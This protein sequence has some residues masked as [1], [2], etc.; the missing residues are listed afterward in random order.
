MTPTVAGSRRLR[1]TRPGERSKTPGREAVGRIGS[2]GRKPGISAV[3]CCAGWAVPA[4]LCRVARSDGRTQVRQSASQTRPSILLARAGGGPPRLFARPDNTG[5]ERKLAR[6]EIV[7]TRIPPYVLGSLGIA[8]LFLLGACA[9]D[10]DVGTGTG[11]TTGAAGTTGS[12][13]TTGA[14]GSIGAAGTTGAAGT[15]AT[16]GTNGTA[17]T[18]PAAGTNGRGGTTGAGRGGT[19]GAAGT[20]QALP[21]D[22]GPNAIVLENAGPPANRVNYAIVGD[23]Y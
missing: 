21:L 17:G 11:G 18:S 13:G 22:C 19:T 16:A 15:I 10:A 6:R 20:G 7:M 4:A 23:G 8:A 9:G 14:A 5:Q 1:R 12:A 2:I 3:R